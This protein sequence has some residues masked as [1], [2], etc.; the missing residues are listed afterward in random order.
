MAQMGEPLPPRRSARCAAIDVGSVV[1]GVTGRYGSGQLR[2]HA[3]FGGGIPDYVVQVSAGAAF[4]YRGLES[5][6]TFIGYRTLFFISTNSFS[7]IV[8]MSDKS[9]TKLHIV[10]LGPA[11]FPAAQRRLPPRAA[12]PAAS[13][14][15]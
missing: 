14:P 5:A 8:L 11:R 7:P 4:L 3:R 10:D 1:P 15:S 12:L 2:D 9:D 13:V 6:I